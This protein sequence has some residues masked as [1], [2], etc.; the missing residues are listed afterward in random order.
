LYRRVGNDEEVSVCAVRTWD[1]EEYGMVY[2]LYSST[3]SVNTKLIQYIRV[4]SAIAT[5]KEL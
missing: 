5:F 2:S 1:A 4:S 3:S